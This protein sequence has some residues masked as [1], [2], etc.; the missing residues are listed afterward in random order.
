MRSKDHLFHL[1]HSLS[2]SEKRYFTLDAKK[3][4]KTDS[5][6]LKLFQAINKQESYDEAALKRVFGPR[7][8]DDKARL[9]EAVLDAL[10][11]YQSKKSYKIRIKE[12]LTDAKILFERKLIKQAENRLTEAKALA[13]ELHDHLA[14]LEINLAQRHYAK[15]YQTKDNVEK[16]HFLIHEKNEQLALL[17]QQLLLNDNYDLLCLEVLKSHQKLDQ[18]Q[19]QRI[20]NDISQ[21]LNFSYKK[22]SN[23]FHSLRRYHQIKALYSRLIGDTKNSLDEPEKIMNIWA[24]HPTI[25]QEDFLTY[26]GDAFNFITALSR[27]KDRKDDVIELLNK[28]KKQQ[29][30]NAQSENLIFERSA[31]FELFY[32]LNSPKKLIDPTIHSIEYGLKKHQISPTA[33]FSILINAA[34]LMFLNDRF[35]ECLLWLDRIW[36]LRRK[37]KEIR[38]DTHDYSRILKLMCIYKIGSYDDIENEIRSSSRYFKQRK[39]SSLSAFAKAFHSC[40]QNLQAA[41]GRKEEYTILN[42][43]KNRIKNKQISVHSGLDAISTF[44]IDSELND[45]NISALRT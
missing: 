36:T 31:I 7:L 4:G 43:F 11:E 2:K 35:D 12:L 39:D 10:R 8:T 23:S 41:F 40:L 29:A 17:E 18:T 22:A 37:Y 16:T 27:D 13:L 32:L 9:Y 45:K 30:P 25:I 19:V 33:E 5:R 20:T 1:V 14:I 3:S 44:W 26:A 21:A 34:I 42:D 24:K 15:T 28:L 38:K 6:Y